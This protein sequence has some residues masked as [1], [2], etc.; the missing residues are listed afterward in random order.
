MK[1]L[2]GD[3]VGVGAGGHFLVIPKDPGRHERLLLA[4]AWSLLVETT[5]GVVPRGREG[6]T[7][8]EGPEAPRDL[9]RQELSCCPQGLFWLVGWCAVD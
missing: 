1:W 2:G 3:G 6:S 8:D 4:I 5:S 9:P 7:G